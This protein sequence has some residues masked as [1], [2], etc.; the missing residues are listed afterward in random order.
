MSFL[1]I[2]MGWIENRIKAEHRK[3]K[4]LEWERIAEIKIVSSL[5]YMIDTVDS[6]EELN[7]KLE[8]SFN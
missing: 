7:K 8:E 5:K 6:I 3:H 1:I 2:K 4:T